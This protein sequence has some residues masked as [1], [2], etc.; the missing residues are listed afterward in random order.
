MSRRSRL[1]IE[2]LLRLPLPAGAKPEAVLQFL[3][4]AIT[5]RRAELTRTDPL[6]SLALEQLTVKLLKRETVY[7]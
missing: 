2:V 1:T 7:L 4:D 3:R 5:H 6:A